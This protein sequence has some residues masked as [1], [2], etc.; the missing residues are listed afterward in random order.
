MDV[1]VVYT[2]AWT[3]QDGRPLPSRVVDDGEGILT[4]RA[5]Q[6]DDSGTYVC[7]GSDFEYNVDTDFAILT[8]RGRISRFRRTKNLI[9][10]ED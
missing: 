7:T 5:A 10:N 1:Q 4:V 6:P 8:V 2:L 9:L 3:R